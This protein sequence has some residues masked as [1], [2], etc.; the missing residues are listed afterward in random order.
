MSTRMIPTLDNIIHDNRVH[1]GFV[2]RYL[3]FNISRV[4]FDNALLR[5]CRDE[6]RNHDPVD[7]A[8]FSLRRVPHFLRAI[9]DWYA[10]SKVALYDSPNQIPVI[11]EANRALAISGN[12]EIAFYTRGFYDVSENAKNIDPEY[13]KYFE[14]I[15]S[16][17]FLPGIVPIK[18]SEYAFHHYAGA[19]GSIEN[20]EDRTGFGFDCIYEMIMAKG[21]VVRYKTLYD[22]F[23]GGKKNKLYKL[24]NSIVKPYKVDCVMVVAFS[25]RDGVKLVGIAWHNRLVIIPSEFFELDKIRLA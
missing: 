2:Y 24:V 20:V 6:P 19:I 3:N 22:L 1:E 15:G 8:V 17:K 13:S 9:P 23:K 25:P 5:I 11:I 14:N 12:H 4:Q 21:R 7:V 16:G 10:L 18:I